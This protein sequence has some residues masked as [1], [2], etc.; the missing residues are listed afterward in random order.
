[1][2]DANPLQDIGATRKIRSVISHG[3][4]YDRAQLD[5]ILADTKA[6]VAQTKVE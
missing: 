5:K 2:L 4:V 6:W 3:K 1:V